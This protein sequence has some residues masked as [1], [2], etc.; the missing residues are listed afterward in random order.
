MD[1][2]LEFIEQSMRQKIEATQGVLDE[3][4]EGI[5]QLA[6]AT[7]EKEKK[8]RAKLMLIHDRHLLLR[9]EL[10]AMHTLFFQDLKEEAPEESPNEQEN[11]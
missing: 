8:G 4:E 7:T 1:P 10:I 3:C 11:A 6:E 9:D 2:R 5:A